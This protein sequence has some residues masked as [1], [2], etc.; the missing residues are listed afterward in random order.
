VL[1]V[2]VLY[3]GAEIG[4]APGYVGVVADDDEGHSGK[5]D[6]GDVEV[7]GR[8]GGFEIGLVPDAGDIVAEVHVVG[9]QRTSRRSTRAGDDP[10]VGAGAAALTGGSEGLRESNEVL[11]GGR[12]WFGPTELRLR[13][14]ERNV[15]ELL[16]RG[17]IDLRL[18]GRVVAPGANGV[19]IGDEIGSEVRGKGLAIEFRGEGVGEVL[20][21]DKS[22]E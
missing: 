19:Q 20:E 15:G 16:R 17:E 11:S 5:R 3:V 13:F 22:D 21:H 4:E 2:D 12:G 10:V 6:A 9:E 1:D 8:N 18:C 7:S 14:V